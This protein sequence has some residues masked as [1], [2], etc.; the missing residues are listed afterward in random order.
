[1]TRLTWRWPR[2]V[3]RRLGH[4]GEADR[5]GAGEGD[6]RHVGVLDQPGPD[7]LAHAR[8]G[9]GRRPAAPAA[10]TSASINCQ[11]TSGVCS[12]GLRMTGLPA[13]SAGDG[14]AGGDGEREVP[15]GDHR[16]DALALVGRAGWSRPA[17]TRPARPAPRPGAGPRARSTRRS[18][19]P[20]T[21]RRR[22]GPRACRPPITSRAASRDRRSRIQ[23]AARNSTAARSDPGRWRHAP[24]AARA[25]RSPGPRRRPCT[26][27]LRPP[28]VLGSAG[29]TDARVAPS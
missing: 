6:H 12:A 3:C 15:R 4:D 16:G 28:R 8:A 22:T 10:A 23:S 24:A 1:M 18:R 2:G 5:P 11:A 27:P 25:A 14:H 13:T 17:A 19:S 26:T 29:S 9:T 21:R 7:H 20:R